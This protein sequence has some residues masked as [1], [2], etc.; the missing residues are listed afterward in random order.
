MIVEHVTDLEDGGAIYTVELNNNEETRALIDIG[1]RIAIACGIA[2]K[3][4]NDLVNECAREAKKM[5]D[6]VDEEVRDARERMD[7]SDSGD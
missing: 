3:S 2:G 4:V 6:E 5:Q 1:I 7:S